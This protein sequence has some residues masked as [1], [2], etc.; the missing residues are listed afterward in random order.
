MEI[1]PGARAG[2]GPGNAEGRDAW[3][4]WLCAKA[5][6]WQERPKTATAPERGG[7]EGGIRCLI[8]GAALAIAAPPQPN[9]VKPYLTAWDV[10]VLRENWPHYQAAAEVTALTGGPA[11]LAAIHYREAGLHRG[12]YSYRRK[13]LVKNIG[14]PFMLDPGPEDD[15]TEMRRRIRAWEV[16]VHGHYGGDGKAPNVRDDFGFACLVAADHLRRN[17]RPGKGLEDAVWGYNGRAAWHVGKPGGKRSWKLSPYVSSDPRGGTRLEVRYRQ[18][19]GAEVR[20][21]D[22]RPGV[23]VIYREIL[24]LERNGL[25]KNRPPDTTAKKG[26]R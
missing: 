9:P 16:R 21:Q 14:G 25:L 8:L 4:P 26:E 19:D 12:Y 1:A 6:T 11:I 23:M 17:L 20:F 10:K 24:A 5:K 18:S 15:E 7:G 13:L 3:R 22:G 2:R